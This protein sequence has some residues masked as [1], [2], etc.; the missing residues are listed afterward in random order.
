MQK[1]QMQDILSVLDQ[2]GVALVLLVFSVPA[3]VPTPGVPAGLI[4][5]SLL[6]SIGLQMIF[7]Q[8][9]VRIPPGL[10]GL[11]IDRHSLK[12]IID[13]VLPYLKRIEKWVRPRLP[14]LVTPKAIRWIGIVVCI[15]GI[16]I[17]LPIPFG[18]TLPGLAVLLLALGVGQKDGAAILAGLGVAV[19]ASAVS[20]GLLMGS[21]W[22]VE[23]Y[24]LS[25]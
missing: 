18:N 2:S 8:Q 1:P 3:L 24:F 9:P 14:A 4:F 13:G 10:S 20:L 7:R 15:M 5:G 25:S 12:R 16:F 22:V 21:W 11:R 23:K 17:A 19:V 6:V